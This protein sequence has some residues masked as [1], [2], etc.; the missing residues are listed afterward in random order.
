[1]VATV[2]KRQGLHPVVPI[3][4]L[5]S[6][7][8]CCI[9]GPRSATECATAGSPAP[10]RSLRPRWPCCPAA[11]QGAVLRGSLGLERRHQPLCVLLRRA[12]QRS[13]RR[14]ECLLRKHALSGIHL[15]QLGWFSQ[16]P[17]PR[18]LG[19]WDPVLAA[20]PS[21]PPPA[22]LPPTRRPNCM[23]GSRCATMERQR[24][25]V[26]RSILIVLAPS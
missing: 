19:P 9:A 12:L 7:A 1:M 21:R 14:G 18:V 23:T 6:S 11:L 8:A 20:L 17:V 15:V 2:I 22:A 26:F 25:G 3:H 16:Q 4:V 13:G 24:V 10:S 5:L